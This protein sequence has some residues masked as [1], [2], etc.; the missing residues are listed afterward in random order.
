[1]APRAKLFLGSSLLH[2]CDEILMISNVSFWNMLLKNACKMHHTQARKTNE[3]G[4]K[5][6]LPHFPGFAQK[7]IQILMWIPKWPQEASGDPRMDPK[8]LT[9]PQHGPKWSQNDPNHVP[10]WT[11]PHPQN[12][13]NFSLQ[14]L[15][16]IG[17]SFAIGPTQAFCFH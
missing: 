4:P 14:V 3:N 12:T 1:M 7:L 10:K 2:S 17:L 6:G 8:D 16:G 9:W 15:N 13:V 5:N 11:K